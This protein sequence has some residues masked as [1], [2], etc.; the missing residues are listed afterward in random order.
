MPLA[1]TGKPTKNHSARGA[2]IRLIVLHADAAKNATGTITW[3]QNPASGVSYHFLVDR[4]GTIYRLVQDE[5]K[6]WHAGKSAWEDV[7]DVNPVSLGVSFSNEQLGEAFT[8]KALD[9]GAQLCA[10]LCKIHAIPVDATHITTHAID[11]R[12]QGRK[13]DP[14]K[15]WK[16]GEFIARVQ[17]ALACP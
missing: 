14:G 5:R 7:T 10:E 8:G 4:D 3:I 15:L 1:I 13:T 2:E 16:H 17:Q 12:P 11:A 9:A 6:A